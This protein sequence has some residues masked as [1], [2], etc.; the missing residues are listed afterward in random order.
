M[1]VFNLNL[2]LIWENKMTGEPGVHSVSG[3]CAVHLTDKVRLDPDLLSHCQ[4]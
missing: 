1:Q 3:V 2:G 4:W